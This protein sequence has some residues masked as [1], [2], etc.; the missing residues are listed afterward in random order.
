MSVNIQLCGFLKIFFF[1]L[2][3]ILFLKSHP[4]SFSVFQSV[5]IL[6]LLF[7]SPSCLGTVSYSFSS[8]QGRLLDYWFNFISFLLN[9][10]SPVS[11]IAGP[12][13]F[14]CSLCSFQPSSGY[15]WII[16]KASVLV[17]NFLSLYCIIYKHLVL[18]ACLSDINLIDSITVL[19]H[20]FILN[21]NFSCD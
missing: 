5:L 19:R 15:F 13:K 7:C 21:Q 9:H 17:N 18:G 4:I 12:Y 2:N 6:H 11:M 16:L 1:F 14:Q 10:F 20:I 8:F 3:K